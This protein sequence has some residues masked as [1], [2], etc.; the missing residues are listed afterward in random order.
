MRITEI[1]FDSIHNWNEEKYPEYFKS[2]ELEKEKRPGEFAAVGLVFADK[3]MFGNESVLLTD[4]QLLDVYLSK[5]RFEVVKVSTVSID[6][7]VSFTKIAEKSQQPSTY[8]D[9]GDSCNPNFNK[10]VEVHMPGQA[11]S[12]YNE[13]MLLEDACCDALQ[14]NLDNG[15][16]IIASC[17]QPDSRRPD[18]ILGRYNPSYVSKGRANR[19]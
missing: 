7:E 2:A 1:K 10:R 14:D 18:H 9:Y 17:P 13:I 6:P 19:G 16:R 11:L 12:L 4:K 3:V 15:W 8:T 5:I